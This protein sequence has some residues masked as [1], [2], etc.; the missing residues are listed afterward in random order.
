MSRNVYFSVLATVPIFTP[1]WKV[2]EKLVPGPL[3]HW[4]HENLSV[5]SATGVTTQTRVFQQ[6]LCGSLLLGLLV[7]KFVQIMFFIFRNK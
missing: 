2:S 7:N 5:P 4:L 1:G 6:R 3:A